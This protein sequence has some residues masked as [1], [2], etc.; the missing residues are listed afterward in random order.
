MV[1]RTELTRSRILLVD[2]EPGNVRVLTRLL[3]ISG[4][5]DII[6]TTDP[7]EVAG[8]FD[9]HAPDL[10][11]LDLHMPHM[12]GFQV[13]DELRPRIPTGVYLPILVLTGDLSPEVRERALSAGARDFVTK[14]FEAG[15]A[16]QRIRNLLE[17][18]YL[19]RALA[20]HNA[21]L[22][23]RV[24]GRTRELAEAQVEILYRLALAAEYRDDV[25]GQHAQ[26]VGVLSALIAE[27][28]GQ[29]PE[30]VR[31]IRQAAP[32]HDVGKIGIPD[33]ILMKPGPLTAAEFEVMKSHTS[34]GGR[35]LSGS[36]FP[37]LQVARQIAL[38]H[39][40]FWAGGGYTPGLFGEG[41]PLVG[42]IVSVADTFDCLTH[43]RP[44]KPAAS[45][46]DTVD[47]IQR[48]RGRQ[49]D[50]QVVDAFMKVVE[51]GALETIRKEA[52]ASG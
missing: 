27:A 14:P 34:I 8:L 36:H 12:D 15:E 43:E 24:R 3:E 6:S 22:E 19:H 23:E 35:I 30:R 7:R 37:L 11:L 25:T 38:S 10:V 44:Y 17:T 42:R 9:L 41:I 13:M 40:E 16:L 29:P 26:R 20:A 47:E 18:R 46:Q 1:E 50:P 2:D 51:G 33:A 39:H 52:A 48:E 4:Y 45:V 28:L 32:L 31:L 49:F 5:V 21:T